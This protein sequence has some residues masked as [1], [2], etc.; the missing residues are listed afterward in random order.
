MRIV[1]TTF[2]SR[3][4]V[5]PMLALSLALKAAGH[6]VL[7]A[8]PPEK[9]VWGQALGCPYQPIGSNL[10]TF[11]DRLENVYALRSSLKFVS[12]VL[13]EVIGQFEVLSDIISGAD[14]VVG[15]SL[16]L[17]LST[18]AEHMGIRYRYVAF[19]PQILPSGHHPYPAFKTHG[20]PHW[21]NRMTWSV[22][23]GL[24]RFTFTSDINKKRKQLGLAP[25]KDSWK[26]ILGQ[27]V[28]VASDPVVAQVPKDLEF[29]A[30]QTGYMHLDQPVQTM[31]ELEAFLSAGSVPVYAGFGSMPK[32][33]QM[34]CVQMIVDAARSVGERVV[35]SKFW[36]EPSEFSN[37]DD[38]FFVKRYPHLDLF[39]RV[40][41]VI[42]HGGAGTTAT[43]AVSGVPQII[44]PHALDQYYWGHQI[45]RSQLGPRPIRRSRLTAKKLAG[46]IEECLSNDQIIQKAKK[47]GAMIDRKHGLEMTV[48]EIVRES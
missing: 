32:Q 36:D 45:F 46:A 5:Q 2:G 43:A 10:T 44:V 33:D 11:V 48:R 28:I 1:L 4:D 40:K 31:P 27:D 17:A 19:T 41:T 9:A 34:R 13:K 22:M 20:L 42:H 35:I 30:T 3:G 7:L 29:H 47:V 15:A 38:V 21:Y 18:V 25:I 26:H 8:G 12:Y 16:A 24:N 37:S 39:S 14:L 23:R 6:D